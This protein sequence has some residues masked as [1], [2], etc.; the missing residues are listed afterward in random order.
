M[1]YVEVEHDGAVVVDMIDLGSQNTSLASF[2][3]NP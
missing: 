3:W 2:A 1:I